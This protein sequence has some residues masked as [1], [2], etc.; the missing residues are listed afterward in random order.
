[1]GLGG[2]ALV[3]IGVL[4]FNLRERAQPAAAPQIARIDPKAT[5]ETRGGD[6]IQL[7]GARQDIRIE[8]ASQVSY[9]DGQSK[10]LGVKAFIDNRSG[11]SFTISGR[12]GQVGKDQSSI[13]ITGDA[14]LQTSDGLTAKSNEAHYLKSE[15][16]VRAPGP[17][18][19]TRG[20]MSG[21]GVGFT[22]DEQRDILSLL[23][24]AVVHFAAEGQLT[25][26]HVTT[27]AFGFA[28]KERYMRF[29]RGVQL[30]RQGQTIR[31]D[32]GTAHLLADRDEPD[33]IELRGNSSIVGGT[34]T[35]SLQN[36]RGR[37]MNLDYAEDGRTLQ[38]VVLA[39]QSAIVL[40]N[41][42]GSLGQTL[43]GEFIDVVMAPDGSVTSLTSR[44]RARVALPASGDTP[45]RVITAPSLTG[46]GAAGQGITGMH[47]DGG[48]DFREAASKTSQP[49]A[50]KARVLDLQLAP[51]TG[52]LE[53]AR[54]SGQFRFEEGA[55]IA[56]SAQARYD[57][58]KG[59]LAL[60]GGDA[61]SPPQLEDE[62]LIIRSTSIDVTLSPRRVD[63]TGNVRSQ[64]RPATGNQARGPSLLKSTEA[65][66]VAAEKLTF[67][68]ASGQGVYTGQ[69][70]LFQGDTSINA[71]TITMDD[72]KGDLTASGKVR[73]VLV[74]EPESSAPAQQKPGTTIARGDEF[75]YEEQTRRA[76]YTKTAQMDGPEGNMRGDRIQ[77]SLA[78]KENALKQ[79]DAE[80]TVH[81]VIDN[82]QASGVKL[83]YD[84]AK[85]QYVMV[86][87]P[88]TM[89][90]NCRETKGK[91]LTF[92]KAS[93]RILIDGNEQQRTESKGG[94]KCPEPR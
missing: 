88:V 13:D 25:E 71:N 64:M 74:L 14:V 77:L 60:S 45:G 42:D 34:G 69:A 46:T 40:A 55:T 57:V 51:T 30:V 93:D 76:T 7:K 32:D 35:G 6:V 81:V 20:R 24:Q 19:F 75:A 63:A 9:E 82:R 72:K 62:R 17:V 39:G 58:I 59:H 5:I 33:M 54:F 83:T 26:M 43:S 67:D 23:D 49:R 68:E 47:F 15:G 92:F 50:A 36:M 48:V 29:E 38:H 80:G 73:T 11:R 12:E 90:E 86:G 27:G 53:D 61:A 66:F 87:I 44:D 94:G 41:R 22:F 52:L 1:M 16:I 91:T 65:A 37:D 4:L 18:E 56:M 85:A 3:L 70:R 89:L 28:R 78:E 79:I 8:F 21:S 84:P 2:F 31:S 10:L